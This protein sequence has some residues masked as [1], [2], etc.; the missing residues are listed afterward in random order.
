MNRNSSVDFPSLSST[1]Q[2]LR[3]LRRSA[4]SLSEQ[5]LSVP[6]EMIADVSSLGRRTQK[7]RRNTL[8]PP[9][10]L[11]DAQMEIRGSLPDNFSVLTVPGDGMCLFHCF[12]VHRP[13][14]RVEDMQQLSGCAADTWCDES[15]LAL[16]ADVFH[17]HV[18]VW[19]VEMTLAVLSLQQDHVL[20]FGDPQSQN[21]LD[22][23][24]WTRNSHG[25]HF[26][27]LL[28]NHGSLQ[29]ETGVHVSEEP[30]SETH[31]ESSG[32][33]DVNDFNVDISTSRPFEI[34]E[35]PAAT[36]VHS[37]EGGP[38]YGARS[39]SRSAPERCA[40]AV[41]SVC[42]RASW[43]EGSSQALLPLPTD[44]SDVCV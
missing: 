40:R 27:V 36:G 21:R 44:S 31:A 13:E 28:R 3:R 9:R 18:S 6:P 22:L 42:D 24:H 4:Y 25:L 26:D 14:M 38:V 41:V 19:P 39:R 8:Q 7:W 32:G 1:R 15:N 30:A 10:T 34:Q 17:L 2:P 23:L 33:Q 43:T 29:T 16:L 12:C 11:S 37:E 20:H 35:P 5:A